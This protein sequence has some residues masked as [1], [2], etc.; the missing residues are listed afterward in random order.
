MSVWHTI[1]VF[2]LA[3]PRGLSSGKRCHSLL[4]ILVTHSAWSHL[5]L[6]CVWL[7]NP[8]S[9]HISGCVFVRCSHLPSGQFFSK[10]DARFLQANWLSMFGQTAAWATTL[11]PTQNTLKQRFALLFFH[12]LISLFQLMFP[13]CAQWK[14]RTFGR[15][16]WCTD[17]KS[18]S[19]FCHS[20]MMGGD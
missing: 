17:D 11:N 16:R 15:G 1:L 5:N 19:D 13:L 20:R 2:I 3:E 9:K 12:V 18:P 6:A 4:S 10:T 8:A 14:V 7:G